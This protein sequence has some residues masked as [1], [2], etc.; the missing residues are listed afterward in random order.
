IPQDG[1]FTLVSSTVFS[2][3]G[4][5]LSR[6]ARV[7]SP[8][9]DNFEKTLCRPVTERRYFVIRAASSSPSRI[10]FRTSRASSL[11]LI[12]SGPSVHQASSLG[13]IADCPRS[14]LCFV[15][16][17]LLHAVE[18]NNIFVQNVETIRNCAWRNLSMESGILLTRHV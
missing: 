16:R 10:S 9:S 8:I 3:L 2:K 17:S 7:T 18:T 13:R 12:I 1:H 6:S 4:F 14:F 15:G 11:T 5:L